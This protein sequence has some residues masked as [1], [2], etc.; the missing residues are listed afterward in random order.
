MLLNR[1]ISMRFYR[2]PTVPQAPALERPVLAVDVALLRID[3]GQLAVLLQRRRLAPFRGQLALPGVAV[4]VDETLETAARRALAERA[5]LSMDRL[6]AIHLEQLATFDALFRDPRGRT[7]SVAYLGLAREN[8]EGKEIWRVLGELPRGSLPFDHEQILELAVARLRGKLRYTAIAAHL[9]PETFRIE[10]LERVYC[11]V[12]GQGLN[13]A[14]FR[15]KLLRV[16]LIERAGVLSAAVSE[17]GGRPPHL[18][19]FVHER[20]EGRDF[21]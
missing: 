13:R 2:R 1:I 19:R 14:N 4:R 11:A 16:G 10:E 12:L 20:G 3:D 5:G 15:T 7:V 6:A 17:K 8:A 18:Y 21:L 9:L